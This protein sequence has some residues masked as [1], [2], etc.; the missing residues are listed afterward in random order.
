VRNAREGEVVLLAPAAAS[1]DQ[2]RDF[3][4]RGQEFKRLVRELAG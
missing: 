1:Y 4:E 3:E 2:F